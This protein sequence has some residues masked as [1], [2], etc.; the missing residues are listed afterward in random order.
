MAY[1]NTATNQYPLSERQIREALPQVS[2][3]N[4]FTAPAPYVIVFPSP[5]PGYDSDNEYIEEGF[6]ENIDGQFYQTWE[7]KSKWSSQE[8]ADAANAERLAVAK[9]AKNLEI[10]T[11]RLKANNS[12]FMFLDYRIACDQLSREDIQGVNGHVSNTGNLPDGWP[13]GWKHMDN[14]YVPI[15][16]V[17]MWKLFYAA[18]VSQGMVNF[19][20]AQTLKQQVVEATTVQE[21]Y[22]ITWEE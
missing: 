9:T 10:N 17:D 12:W 5:S 16:N 8:E 4:P 21:V 1:I 13:S 22:A 19:Q 6:P 11:E 15:V 3:T 20:K 18:M 2:F 14:G 7:V